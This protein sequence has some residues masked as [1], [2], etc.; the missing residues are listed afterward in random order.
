MRLEYA[1][2][3]MNGLFREKKLCR[4]KRTPAEVCA[5]MGVRVAKSAARRFD[6][7]TRWR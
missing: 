3:W 6:E 5:R 7:M 1:R 2:F 4:M